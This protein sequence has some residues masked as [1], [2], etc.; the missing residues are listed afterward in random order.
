MKNLFIAVSVLV[1]GTITSC[2]TSI[3]TNPSINTTKDSLSYS[4]GFQLGQM[5]KQGGFPKEDIDIVVISE[6]MNG[7]LAGDSSRMTD[8][9]IQEVMTNYFTVVLPAKQA[10]KSSVEL[11]KVKEENPNAIEE[12][13]GLIYEIIEEG[14]ATMKPNITDT[15]T[16]H[17]TGELLDGTVFDSSVDRGEA[18]KFAPLAN[19][20]PGFNQAATKI[21]VGG[22]IKVWIPANLGYGPQASGAIPANSNLF[23]EI[24]IISLNK[25]V[26]PATK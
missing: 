22:K 24:E 9:Q 1:L 26:T 23:F 25:A 7:I 2:S 4:I 21:G 17:Y 6:T 10:E 5:L 16:I 13:N 20:I 14:D 3:G 18:L 15:V 11:T 12:E 8:Q 19:T